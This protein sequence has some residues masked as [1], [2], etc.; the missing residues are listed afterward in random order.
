ME[1]RS[2]DIKAGAVLASSNNLKKKS[3]KKTLSKPGQTKT[4]RGGTKQNHHQASAT[5]PTTTAKK[6][7]VSC[8]SS[9]SSVDSDDPPPPRQRLIDL[10]PHRSVDLYEAQRQDEDLRQ[11]LRQ[12]PSNFK[13]RQ[14]HGRKL[15]FYGNGNRIYIP[16]SLRQATLD[17]YRNKYQHKPKERLQESCY[18]PR[19]EREERRQY[20]WSVVIRKRGEEPRVV[21]DSDDGGM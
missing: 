13:V 4:R 7:T 3:K 15:V 9:V 18:W 8:D 10:R 6:A 20:Q 12:D 16:K 11:Q 2:D 21:Y 1:E 5:A 17:Y 19:M 14:V